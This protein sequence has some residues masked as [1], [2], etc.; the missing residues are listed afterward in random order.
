MDSGQTFCGIEGEMMM[1]K[2]KTN[3]GIVAYTT[4]KIL[5][6]IKKSNVCVLGR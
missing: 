6:Y 1:M 2:K 4:G 5:P 3:S